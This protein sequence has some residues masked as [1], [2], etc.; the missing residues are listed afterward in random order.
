MMMMHTRP[1]CLIAVVGPSGAGKD[2]L[3]NGARE[4]LPHVHFMRRII[5]RAH[6]AGGEDHIELT[7]DAFTAQITAGKMLFHWQAHDLD[8]GISIDAASLVRNGNS[9]VFNGSRAA[10]K[11]QCAAWPDMKIIW[12]AANRETLAERLIARGR[13]APD[14]IQARLARS[15]VEAPENAVIVNNDCRIKDG[16]ARMTEAIKSIMDAHERSANQ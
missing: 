14:I 15:T 13:E 5:T 10:L 8:Y 9:V 6:N 11:A 2:S 16:I 1:G 3:L 7:K 12:V 4:Q